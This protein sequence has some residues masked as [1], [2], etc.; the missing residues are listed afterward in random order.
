MEGANVAI[1]ARREA[2]LIR[3]AAELQEESGSTVV[4]VPL[5]MADH[6]SITLAYARVRERLGAVDIAITSGGGPA[7]G[8][9]DDIDVPQLNTAFALLCTSVVTIT[10]LVLP[11]MRVRR[12]GVVIYLTSSATKEPIPS[13]MLSNM[14]RAS[15]LA[16]AKTLATEVGPDGIRVCC[17]APG[18]IDT[19]RVR[20]LDEH[21]AAVTGR[22]LVDVQDQS[23][24]AIP[25][26]R[27]G[28]PDEFGAAVAFL[29]SQQASYVTGTTLVIDG[30][31]LT[32]ILS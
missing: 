31:K 20:T 11:E 19:D 16:F 17:V 28:R 24:L 5:D 32:G 21:A 23:R 3:L 27:Y 26:Q 18:R 14:M 8:H 4:A 15:V 12:N 6:A 13:L 7:P 1:S 29:A 9:I 10:K 22:P 25:L 30:G 2:Q